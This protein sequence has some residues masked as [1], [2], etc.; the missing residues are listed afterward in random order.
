MRGG[1]TVCHKVNWKMVIHSCGGRVS[2]CAL[3]KGVWHRLWG[4]C[5]DVVRTGRQV[6]LLMVLLG[7]CAI[8]SL[9]RQPVVSTVAQA[10]CH[11]TCLYHKNEAVYRVVCIYRPFCIFLS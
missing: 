5:V 4:Q 9:C 10:S 7:G 3:D 11:L 2:P 8:A 6:V 1:V